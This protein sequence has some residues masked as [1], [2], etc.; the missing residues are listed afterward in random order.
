MSL[1]II[2][3]STLVKGGF[4]KYFINFFF[5]QGESPPYTDF[6]TGT[7]IG[8]R[9]YVFGGRSDRAAP[10]TSEQDYYPNDIMYLD[11][12]TCMWVSPVVNGDVPRGRRSHS[13]CE[14]LIFL[15][16]I[17]LISNHYK[18]W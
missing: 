16:F 3:S 1:L 8:N 5:F 2:I 4:N 18:L 11:T 9:M 13:A 14:L 17:Y 10:N 15:C 6:H 12:D 7:A